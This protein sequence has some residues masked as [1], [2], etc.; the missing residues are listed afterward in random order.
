MKK[1]TMLAV[2]GIS[3]LVMSGCVHRKRDFLLTCPNFTPE[4]KMYIAIILVLLAALVILLAIRS[5]D[6][7][8]KTY[9]SSPINIKQLLIFVVGNLVLGG[10]LIITHFTGFAAIFYVGLAI[11][12]VVVATSFMKNSKLYQW[13]AISG[14]LLALLNTFSLIPLIIMIVYIR[15]YDY[16]Q[17]KAK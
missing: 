4:I 1:L 8:M 16:K 12:A 2:A 3:T 7:I 17:L 11:W 5:H 14:T 9:G 10:S 15:Y 13:S 6:K